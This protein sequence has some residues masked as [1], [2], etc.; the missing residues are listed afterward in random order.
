MSNVY[1]GSDPRGSVEYRDRRVWQ[2][3]GVRVTEVDS[4]LPATHNA[5]FALTL[6]FRLM[7]VCMAGWS[8]FAMVHNAY[9]R[10][11]TWEGAFDQAIYFTTLSAV[12]VTL[13]YG[14]SILRVFK[15]GSL[16]T[17][18]EPD[19]GWFRGLAVLMSVMTGIIFSTLLD[20]TYPDMRGLFAHLLVPILV[21]IDWIFVGRNQE[22]LHPAVPILWAVLILPYLAVYWW[23]AVRDGGGGPMYNFLDP[24]ADNFFTVVVGLLVGFLIAGYVL[25]AIGRLKGAISGTSNLIPYQQVAHLVDAN[26]PHSGNVV[27]GQQVVTEAPDPPS[28]SPRNS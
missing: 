7:I 11:G 16:R 28:F 21:A 14:A 8:A 17:R 9:Q 19:Q 15:S 13:A 2:V 5:T 3:Q 22:R 20:G 27:L 24:N 18:M 4:F 23:D 6:V 1:G 10:T 25:W 12:I 26:Q